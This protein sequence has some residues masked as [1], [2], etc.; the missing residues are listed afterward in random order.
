MVANQIAEPNRPI[1]ESELIQRLLAD[2]RLIEVQYPSHVTY[3][4]K[5]QSKA[6]PPD[7]DLCSLQFRRQLRIS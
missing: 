3:A 7:R 2:N 1:S 6:Q 5:T 4:V